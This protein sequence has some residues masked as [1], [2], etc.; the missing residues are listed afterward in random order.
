MKMKMKG[1]FFFEGEE[2]GVEV[3]GANNF[4]KTE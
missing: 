4:C 3:D 2:F 1:L